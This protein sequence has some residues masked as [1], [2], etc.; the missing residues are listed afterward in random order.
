MIANKLGQSVR[1]YAVRT[2]FVPLPVF[3]PVH[4]LMHR[5]R[6]DVWNA[7][8]ALKCVAYEDVLYR[9][10]SGL[11]QTRLADL[12]ARAISATPEPAHPRVNRHG[13][14]PKREA[15]KTYAPRLKTFGPNGYDDF[16]VPNAAESFN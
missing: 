5:A 4:E 9:R 11:S 2:L 8:P 7:N 10:K 13:Q 1:L 14:T 6:I 12:A 3:H 16:C 15:V